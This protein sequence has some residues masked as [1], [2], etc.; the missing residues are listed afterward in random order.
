MD[1]SGGSVNALSGSNKTKRRKLH[2]VQAEKVSSS[3][4]ESSA[5]EDEESS[6]SGAEQQNEKEGAMFYEK[7]QFY[8]KTLNLCHP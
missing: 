3:E 5:S 6:D 8:L 4:S 1:E 2:H 7:L